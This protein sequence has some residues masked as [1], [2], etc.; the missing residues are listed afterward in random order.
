MPCHQTRL[1]GEA[2]GCVNKIAL[3]FVMACQAQT[4]P[5]DTPDRKPRMAGTLINCDL[6][7]LECF[8]V[9]VPLSVSLV[10]VGD[11]TG[12][13]RPWQTVEMAGRVVSL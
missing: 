13:K 12:L 6:T 4:F 1:A 7:R 8:S 9:L 10:F 2:S 3:V 11:L 5:V